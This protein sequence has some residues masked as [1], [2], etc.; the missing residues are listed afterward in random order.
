MVAIFK[1][2]NLNEK[3]CYFWEQYTYSIGTEKYGSFKT[4]EKALKESFIH[5]NHCGRK[6]MTETE[7]GS[8]MLGHQKA[9][10]GFDER[11]S[12]E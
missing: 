6:L 10:L 3:N 4:I 2:K 7:K 12:L 5:S 9:Q 8:F 1:K 11:D